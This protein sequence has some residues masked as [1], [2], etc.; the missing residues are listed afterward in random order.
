MD[1]ADIINKYGELYTPYMSGL[2]NHL[3]MA[4]YAMYSMT[5][6]ADS[7]S[8]F[9]DRYLNGVQI[10]LV[11]ED[12]EPVESID[13]CLGK[14][15][16]Y[17]ACLEKIRRETEK[18]AIEEVVSEILN[19]YILGMSSGL[20]HTTIRL[21]Y[22]IEGM[23]INLELR[24]EVERAL[25]YYITGYRKANVFKRRISSFSVFNEMN[26]L[27]QDEDV[28]G[29]SNTARSIGPKLK[30]L[31]NLSGY[32]DKGF[33]IDGNEG[34]RVKGLLGILIPAFKNS[35]SIVVLHCITGTQAVVTLK[36]Y[37]YDYSEGLDVITTS[38]IT[39]LLTETNLNIISEE[40][41]GELDSWDG[42]IA[43]GSKSLDVHTINNNHSIINFF[44][45]RVLR[46]HHIVAPIPFMRKIKNLPEVLTVAEVEAILNCT[47]NLKHKT[48]LMTIYGSGLRIGEA[49]RLRISDIDSK[50]MQLR[51][52][53]GKG[54]KDR[55]TILSERNLKCLRDY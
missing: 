19:K 32:I 47:Q 52:K 53:Q 41:E 34:D 16:L 8:K 50:K 15:E 10:D 9:T 35:S 7:V 43:K 45:S 40:V 28:K 51:I 12:F 11:K 23:R 27:I 5:G 21:A 29:I 6:D 20:F 37:F 38:I 3:P 54:Q 24:S 31:Y 48:I 25:A 36:D 55:Y 30:G 14:R 1:I 17:E 26:K 18:R 46:K 49:L 13:E 22:A 2:V 39:H 42:M 4:Q 44:F 33:L